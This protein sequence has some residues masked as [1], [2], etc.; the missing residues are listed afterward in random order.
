VDRD[1]RG[2]DTS[3]FVRWVI[4][5]AVLFFLL[6]GGSI[7]KGIYVDL[8]WYDSLG[9]SSVYLTGLT[10]RLWLF[11]AGFIGFFAISWLNLLI[12]Q[13][14]A[15]PPRIFAPLA[16]ELAVIRRFAGIALLLGTLFLSL[17]FGSIAMGEWSSVL[18]FFQAAPFPTADPVF[19]QNISFYVFALPLYRFLQFWLTGA[20]ALAFLATLA[21]YILNYSVQQFT[22]S[23]SQFARA[24]LSILAALLAL[25]FAA[26]YWLDAYDLLY[27][28]RGV[29]FG[30]SY[31]DVAA[32]L[33]ALRILL[34]VAVVFAVLLMVNIP[35][36]DWALP[37]LGLGLWIGVLILAGMIYPAFVQRV[38]V[39]PNEFEKEK[40]YIAANIRLT[41]E[42]F[43]LDKISEQP[44]PAQKELSYQDVLVAVT[45]KIG[46]GETATPSMAGT[47]R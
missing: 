25:L 42:A 20:L 6:I 21:V 11:V 7:A 5:A 12:A 31:T 28:E 4:L 40:S 27:S 10:T 14:V 13:R 44:F 2:G 46:A 17:I 16:P 39:Q 22:L 36:R 9:F 37:S 26:G 45:I 43:G 47:A 33:P 3:P 18:R 41:R 1:G 34:V 38:Q 32:T 15:P 8:L 35:R 30:A 19:G 24:H 23:L 29:V